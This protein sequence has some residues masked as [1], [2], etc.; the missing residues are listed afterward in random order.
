[1]KT[2]KY[3]N[4]DLSW[5]SFN[6]RVLEEAKD[7]TLP[8]YERIKFLAIYSNNHEEFYQVRVSYYRQLL[9]NQN[10]MSAKIEE[11]QPAKILATINE[12]VAIHQKEF[13]E[14]LYN[15]I[16]PEL[17]Q[18]GIVLLDKKSQLTDKQC[19]EIESIFINEILS[20]L[21]PVLLVRRKVRPFLKSGHGYV[22]MELSSKTQRLPGQRPQIK[23][24]LIK[25]PTD[26]GIS[27]FIE[28]ETDQNG[29]H[30][31]MFLED[32]IMRHINKI[33]PGYDINSWYSIKLTR[34]ADLDY[35]EY[36]EGELIYA[37]EKISS[38]RTIGSPNRFQYDSEMPKRILQ[39]L[40]QTFYIPHDILVQSGAYHNLREFFSFPNPLAPKLEIEKWKPVK[41]PEFE[42]VNSYAEVI[43]NKDVMMSVPY[44]SFDYFIHFLEQAAKDP[45]VTEIKATQYRV[46][47]EHSSVVNALILA[48]ENG[49]KVT[50]FVELKARFDEEANLLYAAEMKKAGINIIYSIP[51]LKVHAKIA[52]VLRAD[53]NKLG[54]KSHAYLGTGNFNEK[55]ARQYCDHGLFTS[56]P[57][58]VDDLKKLFFYLDTQNANIRFK[59]ILVPNFN[60]IVRIGAL[61]K[62]EI[63]N[64]KR[65]KEGHIIL[66]MNGF[67]DENMANMLYVASEAGVKIDLI[68][69]GTCIVKVGKR[70][71]KNIR[72]I[73]IIDRYLEHARIF[74]FHNNGQP[75]VFMG[76]ADW[77]KRNLFRRVECVFPIYSESIKKEL[78][79]I[80]YI[81]LSDNVK[82]CQIGPKMENI[83][84]VNNSPKVRSQW[85]TYQY[86]KG[87][88]ENL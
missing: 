61:I 4:R 66:K 33:F 51:G 7:T 1:M 53:N 54:L 88:S 9:R 47:A 8:L 74:V 73:R 44:Q 27:R 10:K 48:A 20:V 75:K 17:R 26:H 41:M 76:S 43:N 63:D 38:S 24:G 36:E 31:I 14:I 21:Q 25:L 3:F 62:Q 69:R 77:M 18:N 12:T 56:H 32:V 13:F 34:D 85:D 42:N 55:T 2:Y 78:I 65:G 83:H 37:I 70:Y 60:L 67:Q 59:H 16:I 68:V 86:F 19:I 30:Y 35:D 46:A 52:L 50:V 39:Y 40:M 49:K 45:S 11:V 79:H 29:N 82:A 81:Q 80:L 84:I 58:I 57:E 72:I 71:S 87:K 22:V 6:Y 23:Y 64:V 5:L 28:L 15:V